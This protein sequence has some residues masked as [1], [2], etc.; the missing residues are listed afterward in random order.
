MN[1]F[2]WLLQTDSGIAGLLLRITLAV[3]IFPHGAQ[4]ALGWFGGHGFKGT[5]KYFK[6]SGIPTG[7]ALLAIAAK[8]WALSVLWSDC[9]RASPRSAS[10]A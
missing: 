9:L 8:F 7:F 3:V 6:D 4:K 2:N 5:M 1:T 10:R